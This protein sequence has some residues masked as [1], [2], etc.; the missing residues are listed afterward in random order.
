[1]SFMMMEPNLVG[2][3]GP[4]LP[5]SMQAGGESEAAAMMM[6]S[7]TMT[8]Q[9]DGTGTM[10]AIELSPNPSQRLPASASNGSSVSGSLMAARPG[11]KWLEQQQY[12]YLSDEQFELAQ[13]LQQHQQQR[14]REGDHYYAS[15]WAAAAPA[16]R[17][18]LVSPAKF[19]RNGRL[20]LKP[21]QLQQQ[22]QGAQ[23][24]QKQRWF[25]PARRPAEQS[26][27]LES[28][29]PPASPP[30]PSASPM[31]QQ[32]ITMI[33]TSTQ[34]KKQPQ[35]A[36]KFAAPMPVLIIKNHWRPAGTNLVQQQQQVSQESEPRQV[37]ATSA[38]TAQQQQQHERLWQSQPKL[39]K[40]QE[41][42]IASALEQESLVQV[43]P[44]R[45]VPI[46]QSP[47]GRIS[48][49][50]PPSMLASTAS[51]PAAEPQPGDSASSELAA[52]S[53]DQHGDPNSE[54]QTNSQ[55]VASVF[56]PGGAT[57]TSVAHTS[58]SSHDQSFEHDNT[59]ASGPAE[60]QHS[61]RLAANSK[62]KRPSADVKRVSDDLASSR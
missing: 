26:G 29:V 7:M 57:T 14:P 62:G 42:Q 24:A 28:A 49:T 1:M 61:G 2:S 51:K 44:A 48:M 58:G 54:V 4:P 13:P 8:I 11:T 40:Q 43:G 45:M 9:S 12:D 39:S 59:S 31:R 21:Q 25:S 52:A 3:V 10:S 46:Y 36:Q 22:Q 19:L 32:T 17:L 34:A 30:P 33:T 20:K 27:R 41:A 47:N 37:P 53:T 38:T 15:P 18:P 5:P 6:P 56:R 23:V 60:P 16:S 55:L 35:A 50:P